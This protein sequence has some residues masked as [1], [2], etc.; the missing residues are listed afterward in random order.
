M[1]PSAQ[2][3]RPYGD[4]YTAACVVA[5]AHYSHVAILGPVLVV[6]ANDSAPGGRDQLQKI[7]NPSVPTQ[8]DSCSV[9]LDLRVLY[10]QTTAIVKN[11]LDISSL[12]YLKSKYGIFNMGRPV[13]KYYIQNCMAGTPMGRVHLLRGLRRA[14][15]L[16]LL[17]ANVAGR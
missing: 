7:G 10:I 4:S 11:I 9:L 6:L 13:S 2:P 5:R 1:H 3:T 12:I 8:T 15:S 14:C 17:H 16:P